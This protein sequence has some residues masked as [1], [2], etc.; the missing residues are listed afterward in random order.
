VDLLLDADP[1]THA[2]I[3]AGTGK[4]VL[5]RDIP[6]VSPDWT[7]P[8]PP[9]RRLILRFHSAPVAI[10]GPGRVRAIDVGGQHITAGLV[11]R[12]TGSRG[13]PVAGLPFDPVSATVPN[14]GGRVRPGTY[15]VGWIKRG[16]T[17]GIGA[18]RTCAQET[19][20]TLL[21]DAAA[22]LLPT[23]PRST[24]DF[25]RLVRRRR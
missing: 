23:P 24:Q 9:G 25:A 16:A 7:L 2:A 11:I 20:D 6:T 5:L 13:T 18:N 10:D 1:E 12:S 22:R 15:V 17:G 19:V 3:A 14:S 8:P 4:A 21:D